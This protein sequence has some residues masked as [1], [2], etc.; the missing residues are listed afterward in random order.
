M[1]SA[2]KQAVLEILAQN[3]T[4]TIATVRP[5]GWP[6]ATTVDYVNDGMT[7][8]VMTFL[9]AQKVSNIKK[10][11]GYHSRSTTM[12]PTGTTSPTCQWG[13][14]RVCNRREGNKAR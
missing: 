10:E 3:S 1:D 8:Y 14:C 9:Q 2:S 6:H 13:P 7:I 12:N 11:P 4:P 5:D